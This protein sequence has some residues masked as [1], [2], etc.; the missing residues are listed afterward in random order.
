MKLT[1]VSVYNLFWLIIMAIVLIYLLVKLF[2][3]HDNI[4]LTVVEFLP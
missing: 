1:D 4:D 3:L 2:I